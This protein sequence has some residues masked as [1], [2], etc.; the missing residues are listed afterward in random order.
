M[1]FWWVLYGVFVASHFFLTTG[2]CVALEEGMDDMHKR[3]I[4]IVHLAACASLYTLLLFLVRLL[5]EGG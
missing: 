5:E 4:G 3:L 1:V 2:F